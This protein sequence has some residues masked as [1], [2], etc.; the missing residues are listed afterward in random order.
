MVAAKG[1][2]ARLDDLARFLEGSI[3]LNK[4]INLA[5]AFM[6]IKWNKWSPNHYLKAPFKNE[7][8][9]EAWL[10]IR[11]GCLPWPLAPGKDIP[12]DLRIVRLLI[13]NESPRSINLALM[14]LRSVGIRPPLRAGITE[15]TSCRLWT[16]ALAFPINCGSALRATALLDPALKGLIHA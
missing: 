12:A 3:N 9:S 16:A 10:A 15:G 8:P 11:L 6:A 1:C 4:L 13:A 5:R 14:R 2:S 7:Q